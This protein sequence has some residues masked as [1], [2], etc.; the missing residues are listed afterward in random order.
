MS[1][2]ESGVLLAAEKL[3]VALRTRERSAADVRVPRRRLRTLLGNGPSLS[4]SLVVA[5]LAVVALFPGAFTRADPYELSGELRFQPPSRAHWLGT[6]E[7][8]R[9]LYSRIVH[10]TQI[11]LRA[12]VVV[13]ALAS[14]VGAVLGGIAAFFSRAVDEIVMRVVDILIGFPP[15][16]MAMALVAA[17]GPGLENSSLALAVIWWPQYARLTRGLVLGA[18]ENLYVEAAIATGVGRWRILFHHILP[19]CWG[20][21]LVKC[22]LDVGYAILL[23]AALSFI[24][25][26]AKPPTPEWGAL[27]TTGRHY[28][29]D[30]WWYATFPGLAIFLAVMGF[31]LMGDG[32]R[33]ALDPQD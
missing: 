3:V 33:D 9:D 6:D 20:P 17:L 14:I 22:T 16:I 29:L 26:G 18:R 11:S 21:V 19:S 7:V 10:G 8:G 13:V 24:G 32:L 30:Y 2:T 5:F 27:I 1:K 25:L 31:N 28:L 15:L 12:A 23:T 4:G